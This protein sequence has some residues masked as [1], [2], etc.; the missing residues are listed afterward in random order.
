MEE[1]TPIEIIFP[2][3]L[4]VNKIKQLRFLEEWNFEGNEFCKKVIAVAPIFYGEGDNN[5]LHKF[6][7]YWVFMKDISE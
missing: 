7:P 5:K 2:E 6:I 4:S 1:G 3:E